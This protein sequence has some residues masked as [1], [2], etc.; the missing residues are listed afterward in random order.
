MELRGRRLEFHRRLSA[1]GLEG[2]AGFLTEKEDAAFGFT[3]DVSAR[4]VIVEVQSG[5]A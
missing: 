1:Q 4:L 3:D 2:S 5:I